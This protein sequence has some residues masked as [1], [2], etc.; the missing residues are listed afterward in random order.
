MLW[1]Y[2]VILFFI[3][4]CS[5]S[6][7][8]V[9]KQNVVLSKDYKGYVKLKEEPEH[10]TVPQKIADV[11]KKKE[12]KVTESAVTKPEPK[13]I[14]T[15]NPLYNRKIKPP[16]RR[17]RQTNTNTVSNTQPQ[18]MPMSPKP[19]VREDTSSPNYF[20][21]FVYTQAFIIACLACY[22]VFKFRSLKPKQDKSERKL[23]L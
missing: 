21:Y 4:F 7:T 16:T 6:T 3:L 18:L 20:L 13:K 17:I 11:F 2:F 8:P 23:N 22:I 15:V 1:N 19:S 14:E 5:C 12:P 9:K 10:R